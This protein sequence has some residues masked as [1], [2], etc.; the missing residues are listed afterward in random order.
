M[1]IVCILIAN[2]IIAGMAIWADGQYVGF[3]C[4]SP[5]Q[6]ITNDNILNIHDPIIQVRVFSE[7]KTP[8]AG[9]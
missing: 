9:S 3:S 5:I 6:S 8:A 7:Q 2:N 1:R 4:Q